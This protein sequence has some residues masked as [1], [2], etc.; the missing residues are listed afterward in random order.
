MQCI[1]I[2]SRNPLFPAFFLD[3]RRC[4]NLLGRTN[5]FGLRGSSVF[6]FPT[7]THEP[8]NTSW[9]LHRG[10]HI[11]IKMNTNPFNEI[12]LDFTL[13]GVGPTTILNTLLKMLLSTGTTLL[14]LWPYSIY[15]R[16]SIIQ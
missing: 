9:D 16:C 14:L 7:I 4:P 15:I 6:P 11:E 12:A 1:S 8:C 3:I 2:K 5:P 13:T 10:A